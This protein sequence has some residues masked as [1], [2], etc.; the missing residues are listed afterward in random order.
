M[1]TQFYTVGSSGSM[2]IAHQCES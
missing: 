2:V 1:S